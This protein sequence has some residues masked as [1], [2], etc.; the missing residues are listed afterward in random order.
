MISPDC[1]LA[2]ERASRSNTAR[3]MLQHRFCLVP[4]GDTPSSGRLFSALAC[5]CIP[6][7]LAKTLPEHLPYQSLPITP[8]AH[9]TLSLS[10]SAFL[11]D[12]KD[13]VTS[14]M[15]AAEPRLHALRRAMDEVAADLLYEAPSSRVASNMLREWSLR[16]APGHAHRTASVL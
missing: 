8:Y 10:E 16:C 14:A 1:A 13:T 15:Q 2:R 7:V 4:R 3:G 6:I 11:I 9:W 5:R 12:P